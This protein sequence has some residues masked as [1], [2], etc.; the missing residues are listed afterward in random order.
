MKLKDLSSKITVSLLAVTVAVTSLT[1]SYAWFGGGFRG[2]NVHDKLKEIQEKIAVIK[3]EHITAHIEELTKLKEEFYTGLNEVTKPIRE[4]TK[5]YRVFQREANAFLSH[6]TQV[7]AQIREIMEL[8]LSKGYNT[9]SIKKN[10]TATDQTKET[11]IANAIS[12]A[13]DISSKGEEVATSAKNI[14]AMS[15]DGVL[16]EAQKKA[17][18]TSLRVQQIH[19]NTSLSTQE[20]ATIAAVEFANEK[21]K[22][23]S[24]LEASLHS[25]SIPRGHAMPKSVIE[26]RITELP[27]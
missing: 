25:F 24:T 19:N 17:L 16:G 11:E 20:L 12:N 6:D 18:L 4:V 9:A 23:V 3:Q 10:L 5:E 26:H 22:V 15:S 1:A 27:K 13:D 7:Q 2:G 14:M 21:E 8:D